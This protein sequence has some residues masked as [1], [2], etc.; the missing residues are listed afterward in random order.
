M[1]QWVHWFFWTSVISWRKINHICP[2][3]LSLSIYSMSHKPACF[4]VFLKFMFHTV[5]LKIYKGIK[6]FLLCFHIAFYFHIFQVKKAGFLDHNGTLPC[7]N[8]TPFHLLVFRALLGFALGL[9]SSN[10]QEWNVCG[11]SRIRSN[12]TH[13]M[14]RK[15]IFEKVSE[16]N[17]VRD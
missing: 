16:K 8:G 6:V 13:M 7:P 14:S 11:S 15:W 1:S 4:A 10:R 2:S 12:L 3:S 9:S 17:L 5:E